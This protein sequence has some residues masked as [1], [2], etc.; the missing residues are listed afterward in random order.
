M[1]IFENYTGNAMLNNALMTI[2]ALDNLE[3]VSEITADVLLKLYKS[4]D[5]KSINKRLKSYTMI[6]S[7][8]NPLVNPAKK[9][10]NI[11]EKTYHHLLTSILNNFESKGDKVCE[12]SGLK[13]NKTFESFYKDEIE[14]QKK[15][16]KAKELDSKEEKRL[17]NNVEN[18][19]ISL[20]RS[21]F[22]LIGG[23][24]SDAQALPQAKFTIQIHPICI[25]IMQF[26]PLSALLYK[27]GVLLVDSSNFE[28]SREFIAQNVKRLKQAI[29]TTSVLDS[30]E[31]IKDYSKGNY[32]LK[33][34]EILEE[35]TLEESYSDLNL[36]SFSNS[37]TGA[38]CQIDRVPNS[39]IQKLMR[40]KKNPTISNELKSI[41]SNSFLAYSFL[42]SLENNTEWWALYQTITKE[43]KVYQ[44]VSIL[45]LETYFTE[46][47]S[48]QNIEYGKYLASLIQKYKS[49]SFDEY[50]NKTDAWNDKN[51]NY[52]TD[53]YSVL[54]KATKNKEW[55]MYHHIKILDDDMQ[56][57]MK[58]N[59]Y[60]IHKITHFYYQKQVFNYPKPI[61]SNNNSQVLKVC[62]W[63]VKLIENDIKSD[64]IKNE[65]ANNQQYQEVDYRPLLLRALD[66][67]DL[68]LSTLLC[69]F[70]D[71]NFYF[72]KYGLN[73]LLHIYFN[74]P[75]R[76]AISSKVLEKLNQSV[77]EEY[78]Q[79]WLEQI[80]LFTQDYQD[81]YFDKYENKITNSKPIKKFKNQILSIDD[82]SNKFRYWFDEACEN[83]NNYLKEKEK[84]QKWSDSLLYNPEG[85]F[86]I[87]F[88]KFV[89]KFCLFHQLKNITIN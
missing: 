36:W 1:K 34:I 75:E 65:L 33:A 4:Q 2:E 86:D 57:P 40:M 74:Q 73:E 62:E 52:K 22:P 18:T 29:E 25:A 85:V 71:D 42:E 8:N 3:N 53:L 7:L 82:K 11:G 77:L 41:L 21:W 16:I 9:Q 87:L 64:K 79:K 63:L 83:V 37:G 69:N 26:L 31:N 84:K 5:L 50:L 55:D 32:I 78:I 89:I 15:Q 28:F 66:N 46:I 13:F 58:S 61:L 35:K 43:K 27:G 23:L 67:T 44:G 68:D 59:F 60:N 54:V 48:T 47:G 45:F 24:G 39:L 19:D 6:F 88:S 70:Y 17:L 76:K 14:T 10:D 20:N 81:Y 38:S 51:Y 56:I 80:E 12:I 72:S 30:I 49:K